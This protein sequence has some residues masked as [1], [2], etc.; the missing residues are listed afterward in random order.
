MEKKK[1]I[2]GAPVAEPLSG[3]N[4]KPSRFVNPAYSETTRNIRVSVSPEYIE[5]HSDPTRGVYVYAYTVRIEN[6]GLDTVQLMRRRWTVMS[7]GALYTEV[8]GD[9]VVGEQPVLECGD[10]YEYTSSSVIK[11][12]IGSMLGAYTFHTEEGVAFDVSIPEFDLV[13]PGA[14]H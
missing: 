10:S 4:E 3:A 14:I 12:S 13:F 9:G 11:D 2:E 1:K 7:G 5:E 6:F 8:A